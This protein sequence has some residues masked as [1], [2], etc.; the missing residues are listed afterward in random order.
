MSNNLYYNY[1]NTNL[2]IFI[3]NHAKNLA[4]IFHWHIIIGNLLEKTN[5]HT[6]NTKLA[7]QRIHDH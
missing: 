1:P 5:L 2:L 3:K 7:K 4:V 6:R